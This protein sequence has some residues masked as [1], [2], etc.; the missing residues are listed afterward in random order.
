MNPF[1]MDLAASELRSVYRFHGHPMV[2]SYSMLKVKNG[3]LTLKVDEQKE[4]RHGAARAE[5]AVY[6]LDWDFNMKTTEQ[7]KEEAIRKLVKG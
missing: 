1:I 5:L 4:Y 7:Q 3:T 2:D 6:K